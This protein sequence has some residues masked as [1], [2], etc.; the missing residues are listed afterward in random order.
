MARRPLCLSV[1]PSAGRGRAAKLLPRIEQALR[2]RGMSFRVERTHSLAHSRE[3]ARAARDA[4]A[5]AV[6]L[7]GRPLGFLPDLATRRWC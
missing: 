7:A 2:A 1:N 5:D 4:G 3:L 6:C